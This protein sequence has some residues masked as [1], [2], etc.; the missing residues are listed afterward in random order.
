MIPV[1]LFDHLFDPLFDHLFDLDRRLF[2]DRR[3]VVH[4]NRRT[5]DLVLRTRLRLLRHQRRCS[6]CCCR[7][8][9]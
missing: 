3:L 8:L 2:D 6:R 5:H 9:P 7:R 1:D 4:H